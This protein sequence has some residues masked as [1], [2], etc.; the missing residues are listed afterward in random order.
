MFGFYDKYAL[1]KKICKTAK[2]DGLPE[3]HELRKL[4]DR[5]EQVIRNKE[6]TPE[7]IIEAW[8][9]AKKAYTEYLKNK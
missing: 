5:L 3:D 6:K 9:N 8:S 4:A 2:K 1:C 7:M